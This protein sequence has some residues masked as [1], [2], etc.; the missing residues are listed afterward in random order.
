MCVRRSTLVL[1]NDIEVL[2]CMQIT[3]ST[4]TSMLIHVFKFTKHDFANT[5]D[6]S[7]ELQTVHNCHH[8]CIQYDK[9]LSISYGHAITGVD[10]MIQLT[11]LIESI[12][13]TTV[14]STEPTALSS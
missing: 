2:K 8:W 12:T 6:K 14:S 7:S 1:I 5:V 4:V 10:I 3:L 9:S 13:L 11:A